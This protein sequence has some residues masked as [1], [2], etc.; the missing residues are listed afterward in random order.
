M[1][2]EQSGNILGTNWEQTKNFSL[3]EILSVLFSVLSVYSAGGC[4]VSKAVTQ[5][6][7]RVTALVD[8][9]VVE[10]GGIAE[11]ASRGRALCHLGAS[12]CGA[13]ATV[14]LANE[15]GGCRNAAQGVSLV[16]PSRALWI[17][18]AYRLQARRAASIHCRK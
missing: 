7:G 10:L 15:R 6:Q 9:V 2:W 8:L 14:V 13:V 11:Y 3:Y 5:H 17:A 12:C 18:V 4:A 1:F 16:P